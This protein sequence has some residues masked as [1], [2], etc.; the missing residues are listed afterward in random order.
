M[1][2]VVAPHGTLAVELGGDGGAHLQHKMVGVERMVAQRHIALAPGKTLDLVAGVGADLHIRIGRW[3]HQLLVPRI[4]GGDKSVEAATADGQRLAVP[5]RQ[6]GQFHR[7]VDG[8]VGRG[9]DLP[10]H[11][12][13]V[14][15]RALGLAQLGARELGAMGQGG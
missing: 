3:A 4:V 11:D 9:H 13:H 5:L 2:H 10:A 8:G 12:A 1:A 14:G 7:P 6:R 15:Q